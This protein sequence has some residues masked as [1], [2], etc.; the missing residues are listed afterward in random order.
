MNVE[1]NK[2][3]LPKRNT[4]AD[5]YWY[6]K[7]KKDGDFFCDFWGCDFTQ[8]AGKGICEHFLPDCGTEYM[9]A[10][11][12]IQKNAERACPYQSPIQKADDYKCYDGCPFFVTLADASE[13]VYVCMYYVAKCAKDRFN[14][15]QNKPTR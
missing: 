2:R 6:N 7:L 10:L 13:V 8:S 5:C 12:Q 15:H 3:S 14:E 4:C 9:L 11:E 1:E